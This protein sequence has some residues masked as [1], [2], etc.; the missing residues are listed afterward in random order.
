MHHHNRKH[1][2]DATQQKEGFRLI[3]LRKE[4]AVNMKS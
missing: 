4:K 1:D 2:E 3:P